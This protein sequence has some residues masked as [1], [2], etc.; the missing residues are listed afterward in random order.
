MINE[1]IN[2]LIPKDP[3]KLWSRIL[4]IMTILLLCT[5]GYSQLNLGKYSEGFVQDAK[6]I[7]KTNIE[8]YDDFYV[9]L[10]DKIN[11]PE[12]Q[13][14]F[15]IEKVINMTMP[16]K[17]NSIFLDLGC[18]T[19]VLTNEIN[20]NGYTI[21]G[22]DKSQSM[23]D[24]CTGKY[25]DIP[26][27]CGDIMTPMMYDRNTFSHIL[28]TNM[29]IYHFQDKK[30]FFRNCYFI[31]KPNSYMILH[32]VDRANFD[33]IIQAGKPPGINSPQQ[34]SNTRIT[35]TAIDFV[36]FKYKASYD[37][38]K[39]DGDTRLIETMTD[40]LSHNVRQNELTLYMEDYN[41]ILKNAQANGFIVHGQVNMKDCIGDE[42]QYIFVL[43]RTL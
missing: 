9:E 31:M 6:Y 15:I 26:I 37:F 2:K 36:D 21:Y 28:C 10:Y 27:K 20:Q 3:N 43:E 1:L 33:P 17:D 24:Y 22:L 32:L 4:F 13:S 38:S 39:M 8:I 16:S 40:N 35:T 34:Y 25:P 11:Q 42:N 41:K 14:T 30:A 19:G 18:G 29:T 23:V 5:I 12:I 7:V